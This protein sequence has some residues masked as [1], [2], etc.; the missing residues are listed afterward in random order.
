MVYNSVREGS[1]AQQV[2]LQSRHGMG[3]AH[4]T[5]AIQI[6]EDNIETHL[7][8]HELAENLGI[9]SRQIER[10]FGK[11]LNTSPKRC[12]VQ[13]RPHRARNLIVQTEQSIAQIAMACEF[14]S[15]SHF[16]NVFR[17]HFGV[18]PLSHR[19]TLT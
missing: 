1:A 3:N 2:S 7:A 16:S 13:M 14:S 5:R 9:S 19:S 15:T 18:S 11:Y 12:V 6:M 4:L 8:L 17:S 10:L